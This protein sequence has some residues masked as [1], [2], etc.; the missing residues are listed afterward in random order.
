MAVID[1]R[2]AIAAVAADVAAGVAVGTI[3]A[4]FHRGVARATVDV[5]VALAAA[6]RVPSGSCS[7]AAC[8]RTG[9][10]SSRSRAEL[11]AAGLRVLVPQR[12]PVNDGGIAYGQAAVAAATLRAR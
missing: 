2:A 1:P 4:R 8:S 11:H 5:C 7:R 6:H 3:A 9:G 12:L 10:C